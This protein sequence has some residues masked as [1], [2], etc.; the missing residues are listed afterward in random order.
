MEEHSLFERVLR[1]LQPK[2][3]LEAHSALTKHVESLALL[4]FNDHN[5]YSSKNSNKLDAVFECLQQRA[6]LI[7]TGRGHSKKYFIKKEAE[8][9]KLK[10]V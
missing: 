3:T 4:P 1:Y 2:I 10:I 7:L 9:R 8:K 5:L 6:V